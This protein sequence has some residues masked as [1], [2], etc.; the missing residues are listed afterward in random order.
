MSGG[1]QT[2]KT[3]HVIHTLRNGL[4]RKIRRVPRVVTEGISEEVTFKPRLQVVKETVLGRTGRQD[5]RQ[6][7]QHLQRR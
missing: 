6:Q 4:R 7:E 1:E 5:S 2:V 3:V